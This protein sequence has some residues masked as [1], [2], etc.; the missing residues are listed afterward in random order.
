MFP[1]LPFDGGHAAIATYERIRSRNGRRYHAD[2]SKMVP[3]A[4]ADDGP[5][6]LPHVLRA[7]PRRG[8]PDPLIGGTLTTVTFTRRQTR[9][10]H[11]GKVAVGGD[12][13]I[14]VQSMTI[15]KTAD[16]EGT[17]Q[18][19]Y[20]LAAAGLRHRPLHLQRAG[21]GRRPRPDRAP[22]ADPDH[23]RHPPPVPDGA[24]GDGGRRPRAAPQ[25]GEHPQARAHQGGRRGGQGPMRFRSG[26]V[27]TA[28]R[29]TPRCTRSGA[30]SGRRR[31]SRARCRRSPTSGTS[32][33]TT[34]RSASRRPTSR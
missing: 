34:S 6:R 9:Q 14:S 28:G 11:V 2:V 17:L 33:S 21:G 22:V 18:Q 19:I 26:S 5:P 30:G 29:S 15:T 10:L 25:P 12:A 20:A 7:V 31:W 4:M 13:P 8:A 1:V 32:T 27:S 23:R 24:G 3:V 16:V